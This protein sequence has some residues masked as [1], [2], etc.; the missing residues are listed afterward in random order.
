M[1]WSKAI[2]AGVVGG[3]VMTIADFV[4]HVLIL[5]NTYMKYAE[6]FRQDDAGIHYFFFVGIMVAIMAAILFGKTRSAW[7][8]GIMGGITFGFFVGLILFFSRFYQSLT[9][10]GFPYYLNWCTGGTALIAFVILGAVL[11]LMMKKA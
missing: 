5:G 8:D 1:N 4:M 11:G 10:E 7:A 2:I 9:L 6:V 3:I